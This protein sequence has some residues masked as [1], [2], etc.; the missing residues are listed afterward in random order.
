MAGRE[1]SAVTAAAPAR[2]R[3]AD[4]TDGVVGR[5]RSPHGVARLLDRERAP[6]G[7]SPDTVHM[8]NVRATG[9]AVAHV[10]DG[11]AAAVI[12]EGNVTD[13]TP[14]P[15]VAARLAV[16]NNTKY[17]DYG[18]TMQPEDYVST[19]VTALRARRVLAWT[20]YP[21]NATRFEFG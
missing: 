3:E 5:R 17:A 8:R 9:R 14:T 6:L 11:L 21:E 10:G 4:E 16:A 1:P 13:E 20:R 7:G 15:D 18:M 19:G 12:V 2:L